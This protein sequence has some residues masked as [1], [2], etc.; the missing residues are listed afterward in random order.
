MLKS[1]SSLSGEGVDSRRHRT[2]RA[3][4]RSPQCRG[5]GRSVLQESECVKWVTKPSRCQPLGQ[6]STVLWYKSFIPRWQN[7]IPVAPWVD[8]RRA[9]KADPERRLRQANEMYAQ[10]HFF[11]YKPM[12]TTKPDFSRFSFP[13][14]HVFAGQPWKYSLWIW[15]LALDLFKKEKKSHRSLLINCLFLSSA[16]SLLNYC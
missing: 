3:A 4:A 9:V 8:V 5:E 1:C 13:V 2:M 11:V 7:S 14:P 12:G 6:S 16:S 10:Y 15:M